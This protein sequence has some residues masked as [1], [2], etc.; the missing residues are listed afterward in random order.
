MST[1]TSPICKFDITGKVVGI[2]TSPDNKTTYLK[3][4]PPNNPLT[5]HLLTSRTVK[6]GWGR[7]S[8]EETHQVRYGRFE[9][10]I[11]TEKLPQGIGIQMDVHVEGVMT[12]TDAPWYNKQQKLTRIT[13]TKYIA[14][15]IKVL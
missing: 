8:V 3:I 1:K 12:V 9:I 11:P 15:S 14:E 5:D 4:L 13:E 2:N 10:D 7:D 6:K